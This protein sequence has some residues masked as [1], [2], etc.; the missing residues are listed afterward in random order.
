MSLIQ[1]PGGKFHIASRIIDLFPKH[2]CY[3]EV[4][5]GGAHV[6]FQKSQSKIE[7]YNDIDKN[8][9]TLF[10][11]LSDPIQYKRFAKRLNFLMISRD[12]FNDFK[13]KIEKDDLS[14]LDRAVI[15]YYLVRNSMFGSQES[16]MVQK[17]KMRPFSRNEFYFKHFYERLRNVVIEN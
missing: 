7:I 5:G 9:Y 16:F 8:L 17:T 13:L 2:S 15:F 4:F 3:V 1:Y 10:K 11:I 12:I 6:L 14:M